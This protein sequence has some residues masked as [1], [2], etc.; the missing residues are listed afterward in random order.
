MFLNKI[1]KKYKY[2]KFVI[3][4]HPNI[5][6]STI[7]KLKEKYNLDILDTNHITETLLINKN[8]KVVA[9]FLSSS[10]IYSKKILKK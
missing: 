2:Y 7:K 3:K 8:I 6:K 9:G 10:L 5:K 1:K 4:G